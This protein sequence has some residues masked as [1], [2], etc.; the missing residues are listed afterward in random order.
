[1]L[2][3]EETSR[4][5]RRAFSQRRLVIATTVLA[6]A[7]ALAAGLTVGFGGAAAAQY[8]LAPARTATVSEAIDVSGTIE[9]TTSFALSFGGPGTVASVNV[10][11][12]E[13]VV[14]HEL[15]AQLDT[16]L[17]VDQ[18]R[19][20]EAGLRA[21]KAKL[22]E[23]SAG[24]LP[25]TLASA[26]TS[27]SSAKASL[28]ATKAALASDEQALAGDQQILAADQA[29]VATI[30]AMVAVVPRYVVGAGLAATRALLAADEEVVVDDGLPT[31]G[32]AAPS[33]PQ[34]AAATQA[35]AGAAQTA[36]GAADRVIADFAQIQGAQASLANAESSL[37]ALRAPVLPSVLA[38]DQAAV[39]GAMA[40]VSSARQQLA[41]ARLVAPAS[42]VVAAVNVVAGQ[43]ITNSG[44]APTG[45]AA[46][47]AGGPVGA[48]VIDGT[49]GY[50]VAAQVTDAQVAEV[51]PGE[52]ALITP[53]G[54][55]SP[56][57]GRVAS[58][59]P[60]GVA[61]QGVI[62]FPVDIAVT[63]NPP[64]L[65]A[66][67][68]A[69]VA[70]VI[71]KARDVLTVPTSA[72]HTSGS[73]NYVFVLSNGKPTRRAVALGLSDGIRTA[74]TSGLSAG[75]EVVVANVR[76][77]LPSPSGSGK[78]GL[79]GGGKRKGKGGVSGL[80]G[81]GSGG[82]ARTGRGGKRRGG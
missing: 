26:S 48:I 16:A 68:S 79:F 81:G 38:S 8:I 33:S 70:I 47:N 31:T 50:E 41:T 59:T 14:A 63:G 42:G 72:V 49:G 65:Y 58:L 20:A 6:L 78:G 1:M 9:P 27:V 23:D 55:T 36:V 76:A 69:Q 52:H 18:L 71:A 24:P 11:P 80:L 56:V 25:V 82:G 10:T 21:A 39:T 37:Q 62:A 54:S 40:T 2:G 43:A 64:G 45:A 32:G 61:T 35:A 13:H 30:P 17:L 15:L 34:G 66:G 51:R 53:A 77:G 60:L 75:E 19:Q 57:R 73:S 29:L 22:A 44:G 5:L 28:G 67:A 46:A 3:K 12:G 7:G 74:V 4:S